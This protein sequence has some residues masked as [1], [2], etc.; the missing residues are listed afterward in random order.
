MERGEGSST[1]ANHAVKPLRVHPGG[2]RPSGQGLSSA[3]CLRAPAF[4]ILWTPISEAFGAEKRDGQ[5][6]DK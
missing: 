3:P 5:N 6:K 2:H 1:F 4:P